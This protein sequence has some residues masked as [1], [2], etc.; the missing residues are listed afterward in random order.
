MQYYSVVYG[1]AGSTQI[2]NILVVLS[3]VAMDECNY[4][5]KRHFGAEDI[6]NSFRYWRH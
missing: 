2:V 5:V 1:G 4:C 6:E 3:V